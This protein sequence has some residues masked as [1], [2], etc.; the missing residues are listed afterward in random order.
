M[1]RYE[2]TK[3]HCD[4]WHSTPNRNPKTNRKINPKA[5]FGVFAELEKQC[6]PKQKKRK[7]RKQQFSKKDCKDT[8]ISLAESFAII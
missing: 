2:F 4:E 3:A 1:S 5:E 7:E 8:K 6:H